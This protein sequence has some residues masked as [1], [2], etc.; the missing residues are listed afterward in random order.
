MQFFPDFTSSNVSA[1]GGV[2]VSKATSGGVSVS[3]A[4]SAVVS[5]TNGFLDSFNKE[6]ATSGVKPV[7]DASAKSTPPTR[8]RSVK[9]DV[10]AKLD[11]E[12]INAMLEKL[13]KRGVDDAALTGIEGLLASG[14]PLTLGNIAGALRN[15]GRATGELSDEDLS[16]IA[17]ALQKMQF[18]KEEADE[19]LQLMEGGHGDQALQ[20]IRTR[21]AELGEDGFSLTR[22]ETKALMRGLDLSGDAMKKFTALLGDGETMGET[23]GGKAL[24]TLLGPAA[25]EFAV[26]KTEEEKLTAELKGVI[27]ETLREKKIRERNE[28]VADTRGNRLTDRAERRMRD[29]LTAKANGF[30]KTPEEREEEAALIDAKIAREQHETARREALSENHKPGSAQAEEE[31]ALADEEMSREQDGKAKQKAFSENRKTV[32]AQASGTTRT[33]TETSPSQAR[34]AFS[35]VVDRVDVSPGMTVPEQGQ[36]VAA[37][38]QSASAA[39]T[40]R[41]EVFSQV[42]QGLLRQLADGSRQMTLRLDPA[43]LGQVTLVLSVKAGELRALIRAENP[44]TTAALSDQMNQLRATLEDQGFKVAQ[45]DVETQ[46]PQDTT[47]EQWTD[48]A[49]FNREQEMREQERFLRIAKLRR[50]SGETLARDMQSKSVQEEISASGLHI[51]A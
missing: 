39:F 19:I 17:S 36:A 28:L 14:G 12:D 20:R 16:D 40:H 37:P 6:L 47:K 29:D 45:L 23:V 41:Q 42:E 31:R 51:I 8:F 50:D 34:E 24:E 44:E 49:Q 30:D 35:S 13:R 25:E 48:M 1:L 27:D 32:S 18:P 5:A 2:S 33:Q 4:S 3:K 26:R 7:V 43:E 22:G 21:A 10:S 46:L 15:G 38:Q 11:G 9:R